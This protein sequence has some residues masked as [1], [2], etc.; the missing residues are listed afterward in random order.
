MVGLNLWF[1]GIQKH[2]AVFQLTVITSEVQVFAEKA[3]ER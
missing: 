3:S 2:L 1:I